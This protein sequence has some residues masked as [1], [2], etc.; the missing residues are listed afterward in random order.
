MKQFSLLK[1]L[2]LALGGS[3]K[4]MLNTRLLSLRPS[5]SL[6]IMYTTPTHRLLV[7]S[8]AVSAEDKKKG[9]FLYD[10]LGRKQTWETCLGGEG[11]IMLEIEGFFPTSGRQQAFR[12]SS[13]SDLCW[14]CACVKSCPTWLG[15]SLLHKSAVLHGEQA[16]FT[17]ALP[18]YLELL[19]PNL[20]RVKWQ[21]LGL[22][23]VYTLPLH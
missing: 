18:A 11:V 5:V 16:V 9:I 4:S 14:L 1:C 2:V 8:V 22:K 10:S 3:Y 13:H 20:L 7:T 15:H 21:L 12:E 19:L 17:S 23:G 6:A